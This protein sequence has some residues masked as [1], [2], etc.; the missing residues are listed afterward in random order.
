[1][2]RNRASRALRLAP[3]LFGLMSA[4]AQQAI[5]FSKVEVKATR[6]A[7]D[8]HVLE[9]QGGAISVPQR[10]SSCALRARKPK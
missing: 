8:F 6:L 1:M 5:D 7:D 4:Q 9:G 3:L 2:T 10:H